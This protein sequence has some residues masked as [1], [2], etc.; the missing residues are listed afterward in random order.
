MSLFSAL[1]IGKNAVLA[2]QSALH[3]VGNNI[4][5]ATTE[6]YSRQRVNLSA[7]GSQRYG[8]LFQGLGVSA[9][10]VTR[11][12]DRAVETRLR[13]AGTRMHAL[14]QHT[15][16]YA[17]IETALDPLSDRSAGAQLSKF[18]AAANALAHN[19]DEIATRRTFLQSAEALSSTLNAN[20]AA[21]QEARTLTN[22]EVKTTVATINRLT[23][24]LAGL[25]DQI[26]RAEVGG[27]IGGQANDLRDRRDLKL[28]QLAELADIKVVEQKNG[29]VDVVSGGSFLLRHTTAYTLETET[30]TDRGAQVDDVRF[31]ESGQ[32]FAPRSGKLGGLLDT[33]D[34]VLTQFSRDLDNIARAVIQ[35][36]NAAHST[37]AGQVPTRS[38]SSMSFSAP[39]G[40]GNAP[41]AVNA[42]AGQAA[43]NGGWLSA[44]ALKAWPASVPGG[45]GD[46]FVGA[47]VLFTGGERAGESAVIRAYEPLTGRL[48]LDP[49]LPGISAG[50]SFQVTSLEHPIRHGSFELVLNNSAEQ[51]T[52]RLNIKLDLDGLPAPPAVNDTTLAALVQD[53]NGQLG[54]DA[55]VVARI[56]QDQRLEIVSTDPDV[57]FHFENDTSGFLAAAG[58]NTLFEGRDAG[59]MKVRADLLGAPER[60]HV[61]VLGDN[62]VALRVAELQSARVLAGGT[63]TL[64]DYVAG[65]VG[66]LGVQSAEARELAENQAVVLTAIHNEREAVA[67][68]NLD[69]EAVALMTHQRAFQAAARFLSAVDEMMATLMQSL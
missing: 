43:T 12:H 63:A 56:T 10:G 69:E 48:T 6:G 20:H 32:V 64:E 29:T 66:A 61:G 2:Q 16:A 34:R 41:L 11:L 31:A 5:N 35:Q 59:S 26:L 46:Y 15:T 40:L 1:N 67:G 18:F 4:A 55:P 57:H 19:P 9:N 33:R 21:L 28:R 8:S 30:R 22:A 65:M 54:P 50:D 47:Q 23:G 36:V 37:G 39:H 60:L 52:R 13:D 51:T 3:T 53:I 14:A 68:V 17:R 25:N 7:I 27:T 49:P 45:S 44:E 42:Q 38:V 24:E 58:I 62:T